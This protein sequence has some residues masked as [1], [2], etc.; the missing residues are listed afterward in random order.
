MYQNVQD[1]ATVLKEKSIALNAFI[2]KQEMPKIYDLR[3]HFKKLEKE[4]QGKWK[5]ENYKE[6]KSVRQ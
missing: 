6:Q 2:R 4:G 5:K 1:A 3:F